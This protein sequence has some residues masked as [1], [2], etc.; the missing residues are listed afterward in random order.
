MP[1]RA[2][3]VPLAFL[4][5]AIAQDSQWGSVLVTFAT[6]FARVLAGGHK[7]YSWSSIWP[8][9]LA[10]VYYS[11]ISGGCQWSGTGPCYTVGCTVSGHNVLEFHV[12]RPSAATVGVRFGRSC[13]IWRVN[14]E[15]PMGTNSC[16]SANWGTLVLASPSQ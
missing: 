7:G 9:Q 16:S 12:A 11:L 13:N 2:P 5:S 6:P 14:G 1:P 10:A 15:W 8:S 4:L 3:W